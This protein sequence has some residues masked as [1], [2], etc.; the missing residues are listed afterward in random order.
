MWSDLFYRLTGRW[1]LTEKSLERDAARV[2]AECARAVEGIE[3]RLVEVSSGDK[4]LV[5]LI[6]ENHAMP[7]HMI[8]QMCVMDKL[9]RAGIRFGVALEYPSNSVEDYYLSNIET[10]GGNA[11]PGR[12]MT[13]TLHSIR[14]ELATNPTRH[15]LLYNVAFLTE[16]P[17]ARHSNAT[18]THYLDKYQIPIAFVDAAVDK[19][20]YLKQDDSDTKNAIQEAERITGTKAGAVVRFEDHLGMAARNIHMTE[21]SLRFATVL[22]AKLILLLTGNAHVLGYKR[23]EDFKE[24]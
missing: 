2:K 12:D 16:T 3:K 17:Y 6:G 4:P 19:D 14:K 20:G 18:L 21:A 13:E 23:P 11:V 8:F 9:R 24:P 7:S 1:F 5:V 15:R 10:L 22:K